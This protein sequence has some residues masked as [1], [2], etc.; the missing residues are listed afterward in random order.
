MC[1]YSNEP[2]ILVVHDHS[3]AVPLLWI[4]FVILFCVC[5]AVIVCSWQP[6]GHL[7]GKA[8]LFTLM[9]VMFS[10]VYVTFLVVSWVRCGIP[11]ILPSSL[12]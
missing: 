7:L 3:K 6:C 8:N 2:S 12:L 4:L 10:C 5:H 9:Y 1:E 11:D